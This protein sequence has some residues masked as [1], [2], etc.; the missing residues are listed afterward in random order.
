MIDTASN[1]V[2]AT[3]PVTGPIGIAITPDGKHAYFTA[4]NV[5]VIDT[6]S[7][8]VVATVPFKKHEDGSFTFAGGIGGV[9]LTALI[10]PTG[11]NRY[12]FNASATRASLTGTKNPVYVTMIIGGDSGAISVKAKVSP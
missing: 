2:V 10:K 1:T 3:V 4:G 5:S 11:T 8:T 12:A 9:T 7:N 6:A